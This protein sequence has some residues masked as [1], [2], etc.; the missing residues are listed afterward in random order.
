MLVTHP[1]TH[2]HP[3]LPN[4]KKKINTTNMFVRGGGKTTYPKAYHNIY[5]Y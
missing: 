3:T 1:P 4:N 2:P 5:I